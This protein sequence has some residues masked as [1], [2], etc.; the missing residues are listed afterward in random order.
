[1]AAAHI[2]VAHRDPQVVDAERIDRA[3]GRTAALAPVAVV[4]ARLGPAIMR[5]LLPLTLLPLTGAD[6]ESDPG[7]PG[8]GGCTDI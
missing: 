6:S 2:A 8:H 1:M 5:R 7:R 3:A 4:A